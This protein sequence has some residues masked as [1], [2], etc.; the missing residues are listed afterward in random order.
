MSESIHNGTIITG[1]F[2]G[3]PAYAPHFWK[4]AQQGL[5]DER[6]GRTY[7]FDI[8]KK[9]VENYPELGRYEVVRIYDDGNGFITCEPGYED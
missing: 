4:Q 7:I 9:D 6:R 3:Q 5:A 2:S 1:K 8:T